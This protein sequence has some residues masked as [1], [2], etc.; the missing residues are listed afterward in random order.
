M[1]AFYGAVL[2]VAVG[3]VAASPLALSSKG[4]SYLAQAALADILAQGAP[5][6]GMAAIHLDMKN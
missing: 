3:N 6:L 2:A 1:F 4:Q 5:I